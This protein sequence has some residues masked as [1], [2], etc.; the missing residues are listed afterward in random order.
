MHTLFWQSAL[1]LYPL[2]VCTRQITGVLPV[3]NGYDCTSENVPKTGLRAIH[4]ADDPSHKFAQALLAIFTE[5]GV[6]DA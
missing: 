4:I 3:E 1:V 2:P 6:P 5:N